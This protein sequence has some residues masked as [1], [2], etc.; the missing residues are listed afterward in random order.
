MT[1]STYL[2]TR[3]PLREEPLLLMA[4]LV[5]SGLFDP[6]VVYESGVGWSLAGGVLA[7]V[8]LGREEAGDLSHVGA[9]LAEAPV[10]GWR[11]YGWAAFEL[12]AALAGEGRTARRPCC[13]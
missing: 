12:G 13:T 2:E 1:R 9:R 11:A 10:A 4:R 3:L 8:R 7:S 5:R 6:H